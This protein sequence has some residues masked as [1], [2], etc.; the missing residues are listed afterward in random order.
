MFEIV[1]RYA[2]SPT[3]PLHFGSLIAAL[4]SFCDARAQGGGW[5]LRIDDLDRPRVVSGADR[6]ILATLAAFGLRHDGSVLY[7]SQ[8]GAAYE[9]AL[10]RLRQTSAAFDCGCTRREAQSGPPGIE[11]PIYPGTCRHGLAA[12][13]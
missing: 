8:R 10:A 2:P 7:Q 9:D 13:P 3:G 5:L 1:G 12:G 4:A 6:K 11:G